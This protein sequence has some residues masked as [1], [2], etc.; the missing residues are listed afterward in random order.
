MRKSLGRVT[1]LTLALTVV[2]SSAAGAEPTERVIVVLAQGAGLPS[3]VAEQAA[4]ATGGNVL[5]VYEHAIEGFTIEVPRSAVQSLARRPGVAWVEPDVV[6]SIAQTQGSQPLPTHVDRVEADLNPI[7]GSLADIDIAI[8][9]TGVWISH[10]DLNLLY[11]TDCTGAILYPTFGGCTASGT[12]TDQNGHGTHVAGLAA[13]CDNEFG[14]VGGA[15]CA[16]ITSIKVLDAGGSGY[17]GGILAGVDL[18]AANASWLDV[19]NASW[20]FEGTSAALDAAVSG[21]IEAGVVFV[22]AAGNSAKDI[23]TFSPAGHPDAITVTALADFDGLPGGLGNATCR[24]DV[25]DTLA[26]F[27]NFGAGADIAAPGVCLYSTWLN[28]GYN[29]I[30]GTSMAAPVVTGAVARYIAENGKPTNRAG[31]LAIRDALVNGGFDQAGPCGFTDVADGYAEPLLSM[32]GPAFI[33]SGHCED[34]PIVN[35]PPTAAFTWECDGLTCDFTSTSTDDGPV[36]HDWDFGTGTSELANPTHTFPSSGDHTVS[37]TVTDGESLTDSVQQVVSVSEPSPNEAPTAS[38]TFS[39]DGLVCTFDASSSSDSDGEVVS[40]AWAFGDGATDSGEKPTHTYADPGTYAVSL[41]VTDDDDAQSSQES[42]NVTV[43]NAGPT[44]AFTVSCTNL[45]CSFDASSSSDDLGIVSY[46]W[47]FG[48][49]STDSGVTADHTYADAGNRTV[50]LTVTD[51]HAATDTA[52]QTATPTEPTDIGMSTGNP[53][54][55]WDDTNDEATIQ[56]WIL[57]T[58]FQP[59]AGAVLSGDWTVVNKGGKESMFGASGMSDASGYVTIVTSFKKNDTPTRFC[60]TDIVKTGYTYITANPMCAG[61]LV[62]A[63]TDG[64]LARIE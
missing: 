31:V 63:A 15:P 58:D 55:L 14:T 16:G 12:L 27:S 30:S 47:D 4:A 28:D 49:G 11:A 56:F 36:S 54:F 41:A 34:G 57:T 17:L 50:A 51:G 19:A 26:D 6:V 42:A 45:T 8:I 1:V 40:H 32:S 23:S 33:G 48:D 59:V 53:G 5:Y 9:D 22:A 29:T 46:A 62:L 21:V 35:Q 3:V 7:T 39:C 20:G 18:T 13:A 60:I 38:F 25:D 61:A 10:S 2:P 37:L 52:T 24:S 43:S 44:A 64:V